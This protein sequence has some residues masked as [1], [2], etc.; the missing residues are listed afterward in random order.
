M[1]ILKSIDAVQ[2]LGIAYLQTLI[3]HRI[4]QIEE[5]EEPW[6]AEL[7]GPFVIL[8]S[9]DEVDQLE[10]LTCKPILRSL[11]NGLAFPDPCFQPSF[12]WLDEYPDCFEAVWVV[13]DSGYGIDVII[14]KSLSSSS[15]LIAMCQQ[16]ATPAMPIS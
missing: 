2:A 15:L 9:P 8:E 1:I 13:D 7:H 12:E 11:D 10:A 4:Q 6:D 5:S 3:T 16:F 14:P